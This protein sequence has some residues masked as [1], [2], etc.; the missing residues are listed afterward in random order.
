M[1]LGATITTASVGGV[2]GEGGAG[3][4]VGSGVIVG[5]NTRA[6]RVGPAV[7]GTSVR[8]TTIS[9]TIS[10]LIAGIGANCQTP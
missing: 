1:A 9:V 10:V 6:G 8:S 5:P 4:R 3:V 2:V 7:A